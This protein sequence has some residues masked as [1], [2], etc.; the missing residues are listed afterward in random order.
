MQARKHTDPHGGLEAA[1]WGSFEGRPWVVGGVIPD[2]A[3]GR[4]WRMS[5]QRNC[6]G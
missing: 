6:H 1:P 4:D 5:P 3:M 2:G